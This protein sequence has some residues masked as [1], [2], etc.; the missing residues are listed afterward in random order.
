MNKKS[1]VVSLQDIAKAAGL[2]KATVSYVLRN[3]IGPSNDTRKQVFRVARKLGYVPDARISSWMAKVR[4]AKSKEPLPI[5]WLNTNAEKNAWAKYKFLTPVFT[6]ARE[7]CEEL[8]YRLDEIWTHEP[9]MTMRRLSRILYQRGI[10]G[11]IVTPPATHIQLGWDHLAGIAIGTE[12]LG[13]RLHRVKSDIVSNLLLTLKMLKRFGYTRIGICLSDDVDRSSNYVVSAL[14]NHFVSTEQRSKPVLPLFY[15]RLGEEARIQQIM[16]WVRKYRPD[17]IVGHHNRLLQWVEAHGYRVPEQIGIVHLAIDDDVL[18][19]AGIYSK[20][21]ETGRTAAELVISQIHNRQ[22]G[23]PD[24]AL[25]T[26]LHGTWHNGRTLI[27]PKP[28]L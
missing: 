26:I 18:D 8:G 10:E 11:V 24:T 25:D 9:D 1:T 28:K 27:V 7:R 15:A 14:S 17:V 22:F 12:L 5:A 4:D 19:W 16:T 13:P 2:S 21:R 20:K 23:V 3:Q 6:G